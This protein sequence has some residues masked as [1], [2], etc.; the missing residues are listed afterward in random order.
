[1]HV[2]FSNILYCF[3]YSQDQANCVVPISNSVWFVIPKSHDY[4]WW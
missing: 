2:Y 3:E 1:M 4:P